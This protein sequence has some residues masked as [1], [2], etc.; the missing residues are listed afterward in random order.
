MSKYKEEDIEKAKE[1]IR[2]KEY[3]ICLVDHTDIK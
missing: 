3:N 1:L 2:E